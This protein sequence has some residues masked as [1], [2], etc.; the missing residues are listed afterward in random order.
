MVPAPVAFAPLL[1][2]GAA[3]EGSIP[4]P[5]A[6]LTEFIIP[7]LAATTTL[8]LLNE[9]AVVVVVIVVNDT[10]RSVNFNSYQNTC[11]I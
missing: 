1:T 7:S 11:K 2:V 6:V 4:I 10:A 9:A 8:A 3:T 5:L